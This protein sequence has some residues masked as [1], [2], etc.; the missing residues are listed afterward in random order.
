MKKQEFFIAIFIM[1]LFLSFQILAQH[2]MTKT[3]QTE[4]SVEKESW[5]NGLNE[6][7]NYDSNN[8]YKITAYYDQYGI[9]HYQETRTGYKF[10]LSDVPSNAVNLT[11]YL[12][13]Y[14]TSGSKDSKIVLMSNSTDFDSK[15]DVYAKVGSGSSLFTTNT[16]SGT[17]H[18]ITS[19]VSSRVSQGYINIGVKEYDSGFHD[20]DIT[21]KLHLDFQVQFTVKNNFSGGSIKVDGTTRTS[22]YTLTKNVG[23]TITIEAID[24]TNGSYYRLWNDS[25]APLNKSKWIKEIGS[26]N[27]NKSSNKTYSFAVSVDDHG[28]E[29]EA[30]LRKRCNVTFENEHSGGESGGYIKINGSTVTSPSGTYHVIEENTITAEAVNHTLNG[31]IY[32]FDYWNK[33]GTS[34]DYD[35]EPTDHEDYVSYYTGKPSNSYKNLTFN[36]SAPNGTPIILSWDQ[37]PNSNVKYKIY[38]KIGRTGSNQLITSTPLNNNVTSYTDYDIVHTSNRGSD[39]LITYDV[40]AY[41]VTEQSLADAEPTSVYGDFVPKENNEDEHIGDVFTNI[42]KDYSILNYPNPFNPTTKISYQLPESGFVSLKV[43]NSLGKEV[44][45][46]VNGMK[47]EGRYNAVFD[48]SNLSSGIYFYTI[49]VNDFTQTNKMLLVK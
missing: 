34:A 49:Q 43:Y 20:G 2:T 29:Y 15:S 24:Q 23:S 42:V 35:F 13:A 17:L 37:H 7:Y 16:S 4:K 47:T 39:Y 45:E 22:P 6:L 30:G 19:N 31:I 12:E 36:S 11:A 25:E 26:S 8:D 1:S 46:L 44:A 21:I 9:I 38:R 27:I 48:A 33:E 28:A 14:R 10:D 3:P 5:N 32:T 40:R 18:N 41:Y